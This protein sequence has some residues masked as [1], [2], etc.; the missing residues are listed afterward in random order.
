MTFE[1]W[2][3]EYDRSEMGG[4]GKGGCSY[5]QLVSFAKPAWDARQA[6]IDE[7]NYRIEMAKKNLYLILRCTTEARIQDYADGAIAYLIGHKEGH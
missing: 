6:E 3:D 2:A 7:V 1:E 5:N 4:R